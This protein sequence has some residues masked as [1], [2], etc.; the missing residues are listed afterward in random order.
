MF[1]ADA[2]RNMGIHIM[3][4][5]G[6]G[7]SRLMG[8]FIAWQDFIRGLPLVI[9][10]SVGPTI[11]NFI[12]KLTRLPPEYQP[13]AWE[14]VTH[15]DMSGRNGALTPWPLYYR[16]GNES[17]FEISQR[18]LSVFRAMDPFLQSAPV[19]GWNAL[20]KMGTFSGM[21]LAGLGCQID[22]ATDLLSRPEAWLPRLRS[23]LSS[24]PDLQPAVDFLQ[25]YADMNAG[26]RDRLAGALLTKLMPLLLD[27]A[28]KD[29]FGRDDG[30]IRWADVAAG[31]RCVLLDFRHELDPE[32]CRFKMLWVLT[33]FLDFVRRRG[34][35]RHRPIG[36]VVDELAAM[37]GSEALTTSP[38]A[39]M[40]DEFVSVWMRN[41]R[42]WATFSHQEA[43]QL[44]DKTLRALMSLGTQVL[45]VTTD[46]D[47]A[48]RLARTMFPVDPLRAK[49]YENV[50]GQDPL[51]GYFV[52]EKRPVEF[53]IEEQ[54]YL[55]AELFMRL[56]LFEF[57]VKPATAEG[58][59][60]R[61][62]FQ[63][64]IR[65]FDENQWIDESL[66]EKARTAL[67]DRDS[68]RRS[69]VEMLP[70]VSLPSDTLDISTYED[71]LGHPVLT[72]QLRDRA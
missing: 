57:L 55:S 31:R 69:P 48:F 21:S 72:E 12:D 16:D 67:Q 41:G 33:T 3:A 68:A 61:R 54:H 36:L 63:V 22:A 42:V 25:N 50:W 35:G 44:D 59:L 9:I 49:R 56:G 10:D 29:M 62:V 1:L 70:M 24:N 26:E 53:T 60:N 7:K 14:R 34:A 4:G 65:R 19:M 45:G 20:W 40:L 11:D 71:D 18:P 66:V 8:R 37:V 58:Q 47:S 13:A 28:G 23:A 43:Y 38:L 64:N 39:N 5:R 30:R 52:L 46:M 51:E 32:K 2:A 6:S 15:V 17:L 27:G